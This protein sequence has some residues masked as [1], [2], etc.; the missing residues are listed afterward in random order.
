[1]I[2][3]DPHRIRIGTCFELPPNLSQMPFY[4]LFVQAQSISNLFDACSVAQQLYD[5]FILRR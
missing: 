2:E 4:G 5:L 3:P 1:V